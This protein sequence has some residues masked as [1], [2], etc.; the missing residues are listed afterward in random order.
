MQPLI[1]GIR[2][3]DIGKAY[4]FDATSVPQIKVG[5]RVIVETSR[6]KQL[7]EVVQIVKNP[8]LSPEGW[9]PIERIA[10]RAISFCAGPGLRRKSRRWLPAASVPHN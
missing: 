8:S 1:V 5:D 7:G 6:G 3:V 10:T 9:K 4:H 2:F